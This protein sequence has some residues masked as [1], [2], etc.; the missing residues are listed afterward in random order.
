M[1]SNAPE[2]GPPGKGVPPLP[3][4]LLR[5]TAAPVAQHAQ[6]PQLLQPLIMIPITEAMAAPGTSA[7]AAQQRPLMHLAGKLHP[8]EKPEESVN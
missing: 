7:S 4:D 5:P 6:L 8:A 3:S 1:P 2:L